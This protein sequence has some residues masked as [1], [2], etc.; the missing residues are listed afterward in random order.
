MVSTPI[1]TRSEIPVEH[2]WD[3]DSI[4]PSVADWEAASQ[5]LAAALPG[6]ARF[7]GQLGESP[8]IL[9]EWLQV[10]QDLSNRLDRV[11]LYARLNYAVDATN[12]QAKARADQASAR[13]AQVSAALSFA[14]PELIAIGFDKLR[15]W[16][17]AE[18]DLAPYAHY[19]ERLEQRAAHV[20][21]GEVEQVLS[22]VSDAFRT[23]AATH[24]IL[25]NADMTFPPAQSPGIEEPVELAHSNISQLLTSRDRELRRSAWENYADAHLD[26]QNTQANCLAAGVKQDVFM[27]RARGY[28][29][30][31]EAALAPNF[32]PTEVFHNVLATFRANLPTWHRYWEL[33]RRA[34][35]LD[36]L[37]VYDTRAA[38]SEQQPEIPFTQ[39]VDWIAAGMQ[40]LGDEYVRVLQK[41]VL[42]ERW[43]DPYPNKG[44]RFGAFS[45]GAKGT[46]PFIMMSY[47]NDIFGMSTLAHELGHS[48]HSYYSRGTQPQIYAY[49]GLFL[50]EVASNFNQ[51]LVRA[52]L[53]ESQ[54]DQ[55]MQIAVLEEAM[56]NFH[57]YFFIMPTL[58]RF[59]LEIHERIERGQALTA[60]NM[61]ELLADMFTEGY[62]A[63]VVVDR[64]R[65]GSTWMQFSTHMYYNFYVYQYT[66]GISG[67]HALASR[68]LSGSAGARQR[69][70]DFLKAGGSRFPLDTLKS[71]G[72]DLSTPEPIEQTFAVL[73]EMVE[74]LERILLPEAAKS[75]PAS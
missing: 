49:Y 22:E 30:S 67:A 59:E 71:A 51:A 63:G 20:R 15:A 55:D 1:P 27:A 62:G 3:T 46:H 72:V 60:E 47:N 48:M 6:L 41:G 52:H 12:Q 16:L 34:L 18:P 38:L 4:F 5:E 10:Y 25:V 21:S 45:S 29:S 50:A 58:A 36:E 7:H 32:I 9:L 8:A 26:F 35:G 17:Q 31:L 40:P 64:E 68:V 2:T 65:V 54:S 11:G 28:H 74:R 14:E 44:K 56:A 69:Y 24:G 42:K 43:V 75:D 13:Q 66:T 39:A 61:N 53:L 73:A 70:L 37:H 33:R 23:A 57:R 19:F